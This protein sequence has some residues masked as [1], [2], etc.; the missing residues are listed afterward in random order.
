MLTYGDYQVIKEI[1]WSN[2]ATLYSARKGSSEGFAIKVFSL[3]FFGFA[4]DNDMK[5]EQFSHLFS[6]RIENQKKAASQ[7]SHF[8]PIFQ[9]GSDS[10]AA[11]YVTRLY[12]H[13]VQKLIESK[14]R[15]TSDELLTLLKA[16]VSA[17]SE[18]KKICGRSHGNVKATNVFM[19]AAGKA[20]FNQVVLADA[21]AGDSSQA[22]ECELA[23]L[24]GIG[25]IIHRIVINEDREEEY[26]RLPPPPTLQEWV[27]MFGNDAEAWRALCARL[28]EPDLV[29]QHYNLEELAFDL[30]RIK[31][32]RP[33]RSSKPVLAIAAA[34]A[35][36]LVIGAIVFKFVAPSHRT[37][38]DA[39]LAQQKMQE[40]NSRLAKEKRAAEERAAAE[41]K[42]RLQTQR[43]AE[44]ET[45][46]LA[47]EK[48]VAEQRAAA[49]AR[50]LEQARSE[51]LA[52]EKARKLAEEQRIKEAEA[53][54]VAERPK[55]QSPVSAESKLAAGITPNQLETAQISRPSAGKE[56]VN[57]LGMR[58]VP[59]GGTKI[60]FGA[61][62]VRRKDYEQYARNAGASVDS[63]WRNLTFKQSDTEPVV[64]IAPGDANS[65][66]KWLTEMERQK[67]TISSR[68]LFR[69][70]TDTEWSEAADVQSASAGATVFA[71]GPA[72][73][74][75]G[76]AANLAPWCSYD[77]FQFTAPVAQ[78]KPNLYNIYDLAGN[79]W[80]IC[81]S[82][83]SFV[84]R[85]GSWQTEIPNELN[86]LY[87]MPIAAGE[88][89]QDVGFRC[90]L[91]FGGAN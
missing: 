42:A 36:L 79:A 6:S 55:S 61:W 30:E 56:W 46:R 67:G 13:S 91:D 5:A 8:A 31:A 85:G 69:L 86:L 4:G 78:F 90:V 21:A 83:N 77:R 64:E 82:G 62:E 89:R 22:E 27:A 25:E 54:K 66:C 19:S 44:A 48:R 72:L 23:D 75:P 49:E 58:F 71:W 88:R 59:I 84:A 76:G 37:N 29:I 41:A 28:L 81:Q 51:S 39:E 2:G 70:P 73:P 14:A 10:D 17:T 52:A 68:Q 7:S 26:W 63:A 65:F 43:Q 9:E 1:G 80:E 18:F 38:P 16:I 57:S 45:K 53:R 15:L 50:A 20:G 47:E 24:R 33:A 74:P 87:R 11:W 35:G 60:L 32:T 40:Q 3:A 12:Q 34:A